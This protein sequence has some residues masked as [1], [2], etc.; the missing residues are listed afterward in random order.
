MS[1]ANKFFCISLLASLLVKVVFAAVVPITGDE[2]YFVLWGKNPDFGYYDHPPMIGWILSL[3]LIVGDSELLLRTPAIT[4]TTI[5]ALLIWRLLKNHNATQAA[6]LA[7]LYLWAPVNLFAGFLVT[8]DT[9]LMLFSVLSALCFYKATISDD[10]RLYYLLAGLFLGAA[11]L[12]K[13]FAVLLGLSYLCYILFFRRQRK[14]FKGLLIVVLAALPF[15][16]LNLYWNYCHCWNNILFNL[17]NRNSNEPFSA[18]HPALYGV[19]LLYLLTPLLPYYLLR[20]HTGLWTRIRD[21]RL[22]IF[23]GFF[24]VPLAVFA[25]LSLKKTIGLHWLLAFYPFLFIALCGL[26]SNRRLIALLKFMIPFSALHLLAVA[27]LLLLPPSIFS[28]NPVLYKTLLM[29]AHPEQTRQALQPWAKTYHFATES[30]VR[31]AILA[32]Y[33]DQ[34]VM[35]IGNGSKH[36]RQDDLLTDLRLLQGENILIFAREAIAPEAYKSYFEQLTAEEITIDGVTFPVLLGQGFRYEPYRDSILTEVK[37]RFYNIP[38]FL[39][40]GACYFLQRYFP[41]Q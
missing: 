12:S 3:L 1:N 21:S 9:P 8:T 25:L 14:A 23:S 34:P 37:A 26:L 39:P 5:I 18:L 32:Y 27:V 11:F 4:A 15:V 35:V 24:M 22:M 36:A 41:S 40:Y 20:E 13:Y 16:L 31:S 2:A 38:E 7:S 28:S 30:Y 10:R 6:L 29:S 33:T 19:L 17:M